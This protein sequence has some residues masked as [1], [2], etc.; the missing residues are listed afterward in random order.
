LRYA[1]VTVF[2]PLKT[3]FLRPINRGQSKRS[4]S[5]EGDYKKDAARAA[6]EESTYEMKT[7]RIRN[8]KTIEDSGVITCH[9]V[10]AFVGKNEAGII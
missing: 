9:D 3:F 5:S 6:T 10:T 8:F 1:N 7:F 2:T 4:D